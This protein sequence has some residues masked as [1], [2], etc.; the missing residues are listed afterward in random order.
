MET[1]VVASFGFHPIQWIGQLLGVIMDG[2]FRVTSAVGI[3]NIGLCIIIF[4]ILVKIDGG[5]ATRNSS[6]SKEV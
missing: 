2:I 1:N 5:Y 3:M 6:H 4:T